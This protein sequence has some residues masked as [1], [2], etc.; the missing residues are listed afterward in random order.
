MMPR[1]AWLA[2]FRYLKSSDILCVGLSCKT[3]YRIANALLVLYKGPSVALARIH[4][5]ASSAAV[6]VQTAP[7][8]LQLNDGLACLGPQ[9]E[10]INVRT[11]RVDSVK[12]GRAHEHCPFYVDG[13][14]RWTAFYDDEMRLCVFR[15]DMPGSSVCRTDLTSPVYAGI[16]WLGNLARPWSLFQFNRTERIRALV[17]RSSGAVF[18]LPSSEAF[19]AVTGYVDKLFGCGDFLYS[20]SSI[21]PGTAAVVEYRLHESDPPDANDTRLVFELAP[22]TGPWLSVWR[23]ALHCGDEDFYSL[24]ESPDASQCASPDRLY[25]LADDSSSGFVTCMLSYFPLERRLSSKQCSGFLPTIGTGGQLLY[26]EV[27][28][29]C[30]S[31]TQIGD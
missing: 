4:L 7:R 19:K 9:T 31:L 18:S 29:L 23:R 10:V 3:I 12:L 22:S 8:L 25:V 5:P 13:S 6:A 2:V 30:V 28:S 24:L 26:H 27:A 17:N 20:I 1:D 16:E 11:L 21:G 15:L 14:E